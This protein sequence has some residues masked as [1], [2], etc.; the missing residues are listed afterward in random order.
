MDILWTPSDPDWPA[1]LDIRHMHVHIR[2]TS[3]YPV[4]ARLVLEVH[5]DAVPEQIAGFI[6][7]AA[8]RFVDT[9]P[10]VMR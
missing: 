4:Q 2:M 10:C 6:N 3:S 8:A 7:R 5:D 1:F 9:L